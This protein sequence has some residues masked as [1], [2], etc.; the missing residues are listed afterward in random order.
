[1]RRYAVKGGAPLVGEVEIG[2]AKNAALGILAAAL[3]SDETVEIENVP[4]V[5]ARDLR[6]IRG[7][8][9]QIMTMSKKDPNCMEDFIDVILTDEDEVMDAMA[10]LRSVYPNVL[11]ISYDNKAT[12]AFE[13]VENFSNAREKNPLEVFEAFYLSRRGQEMSLEQKEYIQSAIDSIW[14]EN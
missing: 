8:L 4:L 14:G 7:T 11:K 1:M 12:R 13:N 3:M 5:P 9:D 10:T 2:G 6:Q